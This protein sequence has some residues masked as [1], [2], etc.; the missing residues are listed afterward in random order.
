MATATDLLVVA[1]DAAQSALVDA[2]LVAAGSAA[3]AS[4]NEQWFHTY[5]GVKIND[6]LRCHYKD[7][8]SKLLITFETSVGWIESCFSKDGLRGR[9]P[10]DLTDRQRFDV[11]VWSKGQMPAGL[12]EIKNEPLAKIAAPSDLK[13]LRDGLLRWHRSRQGTVSW[14]LF[15]FCVRC[16][17]TRNVDRLQKIHDKI[18]ALRGLAEKSFPEL[19]L[20]QHVFDGALAEDASALWAGFLLQ[21]EAV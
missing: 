1:V 15:L 12:I 11:L 8:S 7:S 13:K 19:K 21:R 16:D 5:V 9:V 20:T 18:G 17:D 3:K 2:E 14:G 6:F 10:G 4:R